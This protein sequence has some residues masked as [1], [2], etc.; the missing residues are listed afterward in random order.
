MNPLSNGNVLMETTPWLDESAKL[1]N[2]LKLMIIK[3][4]AIPS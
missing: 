4:V 3:G 1:S 2:K